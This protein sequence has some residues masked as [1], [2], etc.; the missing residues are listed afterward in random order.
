MK[1]LIV[2]ALILAISYSF[3]GVMPR[4]DQSCDGSVPGVFWDGQKC[5]T[6]SSGACYCKAYLECDKC[7]EGFSM[8]N[9]SEEVKVRMRCYKCPAGVKD[10]CFHGVS[11]FYK[12]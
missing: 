3:N 5:D 6:C 7:V 4:S 1:F 8:Y 11:T 2:L 9:P 12:P 10:C